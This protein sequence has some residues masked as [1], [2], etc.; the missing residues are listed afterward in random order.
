[1]RRALV[2]TVSIAALLAAALPAQAKVA[3]TGSISGPGLGGGEGG[4]V[5]TISI[6]RPD[7]PLL[8]GLF[9]RRDGSR[10]PPTEALGPRYTARF[11]TRLPPGVPEVVQHLYPFAKGGPLIY[12]AP[13]QEWI[14]PR[15]GTAPSGWFPMTRQLLNQLTAWGLPETAPAPVQTPAVQAQQQPAPSGPSPVVWATL[16]LAGLLVLSAAAGR[17]A[18]VRRAA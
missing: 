18:I 9:E 15:G 17:R 5:R 11:L 3:G 13:G 12:T 2:M 6:D 16:L 8:A 1:M 10:Q 7:Y 14:G 4:D